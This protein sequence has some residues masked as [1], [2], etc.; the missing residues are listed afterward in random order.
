MTDTEYYD[1]DRSSGEAASAARTVFLVVLMIIAVAGAAGAILMNVWYNGQIAEFRR[2]DQSVAAIAA[3]ARDL[4]TLNNVISGASVDGTVPPLT[5]P[6][7][8][9]LYDVWRRD[10][11][12]LRGIVTTDPVP[13]GAGGRRGNYPPIHDFVGPDN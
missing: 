13:P 4:D 12:R 7:G 2:K 5:F 8:Q 10:N 1:N 3:Y 6:D 9:A 11:D